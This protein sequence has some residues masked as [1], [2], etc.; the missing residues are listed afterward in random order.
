MRIRR[1][2]VLIDGGFF[3]KR[4]SR[5]VAPHRCDTAAAVANSARL[6]CKRHVQKLIGEPFK[7]PH[8]KWLDQ[9]S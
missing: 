1:I 9:V 6:L 3:I 5:L 4:L 7:A 2:A 8:S